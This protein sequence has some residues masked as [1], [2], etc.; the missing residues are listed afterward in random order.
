M[1]RGYRETLEKD[2]EGFLTL[3]DFTKPSLLKLSE[4]QNLIYRESDEPS[5]HTELQMEKPQTQAQKEYLYVYLYLFIYRS[6]N[7]G[8]FIAT[9][10]LHL[11]SVQLIPAPR[12]LKIIL[13]QSIFA[14]ATGMEHLMKTSHGG[15]LHLN[16]AIWAFFHFLS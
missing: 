3:F 9:P 13:N 16:L 2:A 6:S 7:N 14:T 5:D 8:T 11:K 4:T 12:L 15:C 10:G 1:K